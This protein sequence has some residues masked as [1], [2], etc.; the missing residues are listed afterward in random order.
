MI[1]NRLYRLVTNDMHA[2]LAREFDLTRR[3]TCFSGYKGAADAWEAYL[4]ALLISNGR[5]ALLEFYAP[6]LRRE[7][8]AVQFLHRFDRLPPVVT[9]D[10]SSLQSPTT[11]AS[12]PAPVP[13]VATAA[14]NVPPTS[15]KSFSKRDAAAVAVGATTAATGVPK[16][17]PAPS[18]APKVLPAQPPATTTALI[19][20]QIQAAKDFVP[21]PKKLSK[22]R[23]PE[24]QSHAASGSTRTL[25]C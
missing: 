13:S 11:A 19:I 17:P 4:A 8:L 24:G 5:R 20:E 1:R 21:T 7:Y 18:K 16:G 2:N 3:V 15:T 23:P 25:V 9:T 14:A 12:A 22:L 6:L 10:T